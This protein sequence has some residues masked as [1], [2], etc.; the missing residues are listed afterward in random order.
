MYFNNIV[1]ETVAYMTQ[2]Y[3]FHQLKMIFKYTLLLLYIFSLL[4]Q[5][6]NLYIKIENN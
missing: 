3:V 5:F 1:F 2:F 6:S 4:N